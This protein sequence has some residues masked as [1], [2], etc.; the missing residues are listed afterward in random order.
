MV[1]SKTNDTTKSE[2]KEKLVSTTRVSLISLTR[3]P[4]PWIRPEVVQHV[5]VGDF[6]P[7]GAGWA[8]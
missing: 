8:E 2:A 7:T 4:A 1:Q 6:G 3:G 5:I